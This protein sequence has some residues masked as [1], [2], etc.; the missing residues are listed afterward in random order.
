MTC[1]QDN[2]KELSELKR[3]YLQHCL[4]GKSYKSTVANRA[5]PCLHGG[6]LKIHT[7]YS[8]FKIPT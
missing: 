4:S 3:E 5:L 2:I 8:P 7:A 6:S 1:A